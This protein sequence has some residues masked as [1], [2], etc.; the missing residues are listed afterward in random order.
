MRRPEENK[1]HAHAHTYTL[2]NTYH[3]H[4][5]FPDLFIQTLLSGLLATVVSDSQ[6]RFSPERGRLFP[7]TPEQT[8]GSLT[9]ELHLYVS[10]IGGGFVDSAF[11]HRV[12]VQDVKRS[13]E[14]ENL[15]PFGL[16]DNDVEGTTLSR[17]V[18]HH[19]RLPD[20]FSV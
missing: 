12:C 8:F 4:L 19:M 20:R 17:T 7:Q 13:A 11:I 9:A 14:T 2:T 1:K 18:W 5:Q 16:L 10:Q 6:L 15:R 3:L